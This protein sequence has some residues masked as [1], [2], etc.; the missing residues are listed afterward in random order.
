MATFQRNFI[1]GKMNK[2]VDERLV[3]NGQYIDALNV[4]LGSSESTEV[5]ALENSK[6]NTKLTSIGY[7]GELLSTSARCIGA[8]EDGANETLYW[9]IHDSG[10]TSSPTGK[11]DLILSY[12]SATNNLIYHVV[13]V[14]KGGATPTETVL[15]FNEKY[16]ITGINLVDGL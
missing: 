13:S 9:F 11:L 7:Q 8:Y 1:A 16:L 12:N 5:G 10:F 2:S 6:G 3:P 14:S 4:R 15:N